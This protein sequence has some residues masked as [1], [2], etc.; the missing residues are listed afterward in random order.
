MAQDDSQWESP[1][2]AP[3]A[4]ARLPWLLSP[5][6]SLL[7]CLL[8]VG[9]LFTSSCRVPD[10]SED[11]FHLHNESVLEMLGAEVGNREIRRRDL[12]RR[13]ERLER[14]IEAQQED[15]QDIENRELLVRSRLIEKRGELAAALAAL[16][17]LEG[18]LASQDARAKAVR[19][20]LETIRAQEKE[21]AQLTARKKALPGEIAALKKQVAA[22]AA[23]KK[24]QADQLP[25]PPKKPAP[26]KA[27]ATPAKK[28]TQKPAEA[29]AKKNAPKPA[30]TKS[31]QA[32]AKKKDE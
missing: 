27:A 1:N 6:L 12:I 25:P 19:K 2:E 20:E 17:K 8:L 5:L 9:S 18:A 24:A 26:A 32:P 16:K 14:A 7:W 11:D 3:S 23:Q 15:L 22:L 13:Q 31:N 29:P 28:P 30:P 21:L 10:A 4:W